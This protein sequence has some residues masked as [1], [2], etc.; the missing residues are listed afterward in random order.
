M[1]PL[2]Y[3]KKLFLKSQFQNVVADE[4]SA[5]QNNLLHLHPQV[6][7]VLMAVGL[8]NR[9]HTAVMPRIISHKNL[10]QLFLPVC[11]CRDHR[12]WVFINSYYSYCK[13][14]NRDNIFTIILP[15]VLFYLPI[16]L[17]H[18]ECSGLEVNQTGSVT[19]VNTV[20]LMCSMLDWPQCHK[21]SFFTYIVFWK[22]VELCEMCCRI[23]CTISC[24]VV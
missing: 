18:Y 24:A 9:I 1:K 4:I 22:F 3:T 11:Y 7:T 6:W 21:Q 5:L 15:H 23:A 10:L 13:S 8:Q 17:S 20:C 16:Y 12:Y 19:E 2:P 14:C